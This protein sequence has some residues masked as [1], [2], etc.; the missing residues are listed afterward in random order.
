MH[1][2]PP[3]PHDYSRILRVYIYPAPDFADLAI[4]DYPEPIGPKVY[5]PIEELWHP[6]ADELEQ[7]ARDVHDAHSDVT[8]FEILAYP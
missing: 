7:L 1:P 6:L 2:T 5:D 8:G 4:V 3:E